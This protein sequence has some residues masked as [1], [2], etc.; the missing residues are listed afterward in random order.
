VPTHR[1]RVPASAD[2]DF[3]AIRAELEVPG[4]FSGAAMEDARATA[5]AGPADPSGPRRDATDLPLV[6]IDPPGSTDLDQAVAIADHGDGWRVT[7]A[8][9][10]VAAF[11]RPGGALDAEVRRRT[12]TY[13]APDG[14]APLHP[15]ALGEAAASLLPDGPRP[16]VLWTID[17]DAAGRTTDVA[18]ERA[19]VRSRAQLSYAEA[20]ALLDRGEAPAALAPLPHIGE[21]LLEDAVTRGAI[22]L[23]LPEQEVVPDGSGG[24]TVTLRADLP[25]ERWN[26]Q[27][28]LLTGRAAAW[29]SLEGGIGLLRTLPSP[30]PAALPRLRQAA[31]NLGIAWPDGAGPGQVL[32]GLDTRTGPHAAFADLA[33]ELLRG[34]AYTAVRGRPPADPGH[35]GVGSPYAHVTAPLRRLVDRYA[36]EV[37]LA[38]ASGTQVPGWVDEALDALPATMAEGDARSRRLDRAIVDATEAFV[39]RD[40][41]GATFA[42]QVIETGED[43][44]TVVLAE[45]P[46]RA[47]CDTSDLPLGREILVRCTEADVARRSVRFARV[48]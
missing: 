15:A 40:H 5:A 17:V 16:A 13:Y 43:R 8:I 14:R 37:C 23:G 19:T 47:R 42:A 12:Q 44:G 1:I 36:T 11:V 41:V 34:A 48:S 26:A 33:G 7:Y 30:D 21:V 35:A 18:V 38:L 46:V 29:I 22:D 2:L 9:A 6:T 3:D 27:I 31:E 25:V 32:A 10:D 28:S 24:W 20:Q 45:P 4:E 39:L